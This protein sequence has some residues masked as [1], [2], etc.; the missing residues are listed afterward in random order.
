MERDYCEGWTAYL[1]GPLGDPDL[2]LE[3]VVEVILRSARVSDFLTSKQCSRVT[4]DVVLEV[5][6]VDVVPMKWKEGD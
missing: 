3:R 4:H 2:E 6:P 1:A 5:A